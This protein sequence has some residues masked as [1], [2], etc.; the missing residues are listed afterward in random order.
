MVVFF[1]FFVVC[2]DGDMEP[3]DDDFDVYVY[4]HD[5]YHVR[6]EKRKRNAF[7]NFVEQCL[8]PNGNDASLAR[9]FY[10]LLPRASPRFKATRAEKVKNHF[11][12]E[13]Y[14]GKVT[15]DTAGFCEKNRDELHPE[16]ENLVKQ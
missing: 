10:E 12:V 1:F 16:I 4:V 13:H 7:S 2:V 3:R 8:F 14:A 11:T 15:Y 5:G 6:N 9:K